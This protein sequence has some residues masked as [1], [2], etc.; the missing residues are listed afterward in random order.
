MIIDIPTGD[1]FRNT[2]IAY[3]NLAWGN[4]IHLCFTLDGAEEHFYERDE[5]EIDKISDDYW[6]AAQKPL[7]AASSLLHQG[8]EF[9]LMA[10]I[11]D[12]SPFLLVDGSPRDWPRHC[13]KNDTSFAEFKTIDAQ[14]LIRAYN[15]VSPTRLDDKFI[16]LYNGL[17]NQRNSIVHTVDKNLRL[18]STEILI[19]I[20]KVADVLIGS[21]QWMTIRA[22][23]IKQ[24]YGSIPFRE[25]K[26]LDSH[27]VTQLVYEAQYLIDNLQ[28]AELKRFFGFNR[29]QR[30]YYCP[31]CASESR[32]WDIDITTAQLQPNVETSTTIY[33]FVCCQE[34]E[35][36]RKACEY[37]DCLGNVIV[38]DTCLT[39]FG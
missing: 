21:R 11:A 26:Y 34:Y 38:D 35:V 17:R 18:S 3:L 23:D 28:T 37:E 27:N 14:Q 10:Q 15:A 6:N 25:S 29:R 39:C 16:E 2:G 13:D 9:L 20:L 8:S 33:C 24:G 4:V 30:A 12:I 22:N 32:Q 1:D 36:L 31:N 5:E 19:D 7:A